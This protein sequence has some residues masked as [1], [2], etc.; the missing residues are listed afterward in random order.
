[1][2]IHL[3]MNRRVKGRTSVRV[4]GNQIN[5]EISIVSISTLCC[6][7]RHFSST[8][9]NIVILDKILDLEVKF[10]NLY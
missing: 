10:K 2:Y 1:M 5:S 4:G 9:F 7:G 6:E 3:L 8:R